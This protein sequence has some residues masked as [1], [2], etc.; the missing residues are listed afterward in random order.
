MPI[1]VMAAPKDALKLLQAGIEKHLAAG[2]VD[3]ELARIEGLGAPHRVF[4]L[5]LDA[6]VAGTPIAKAARLVGW[7]ATLVDRA[8]KAI[9]AAELIAKGSAL[10][11]ACVARGGH[12]A[13]IDASEAAAEAWSRQAKGDH[14]LALLRVPGAYC[15]AL[16]LRGAD[17]GRDAFIP[18]AP[19]PAGL[20]PNA[21]YAEAELR[22]ALLPE[23]R[24]QLAA[25]SE[26]RTTD[27]T[28]R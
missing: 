20:K 7:R 17:G 25:P 6:L 10:S 22:A 3:A 1:K 16:W 5:G 13:G 11:F 9:A 8:R 26:D 19:C 28:T 12:V 21:I 2:L 18:I 14:E 23:A 4:H 15:V 27:R 24:K